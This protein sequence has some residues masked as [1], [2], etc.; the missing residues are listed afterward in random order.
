[1]YCVGRESMHECVRKAY[2]LQGR[3]YLAGVHVKAG[4]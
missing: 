3:Q 4:V 2:I 1:M